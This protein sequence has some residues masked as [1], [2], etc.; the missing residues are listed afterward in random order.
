MLETYREVMQDHFDLPALR[1]VLTDI[2]KRTTRVVEADTDSPSPFASSLMFDFIASF[3]YEYDAPIAERRAAALALDRTLLADLLGEPE[4]RELLDSDAI[5]SVE[6]DLQHLSPDRRVR[7]RDGMSDMLRDIGPLT[8]NE[9]SDRTEQAEMAPLWLDE[10]VRSRRVVLLPVNGVNKYMAVE[11]IARLRDT[12]GVQPSPGIATD[13]L[14][15]VADPLGDVIGRYA[16]THGPFTDKEA[17]QVIGLPT[18]AIAEVLARLER[19][20]RVAAGAYRPGGIER[21]W[22]SIDVLRRLRRR[23]LASLA[24]QVEAVDHISY[25]RFLPA[26]QRFSLDR[27]T[28]LP[29]VVRQLSGAAI[30]ASVLERDVLAARIENPERELDSALATGDI[31]WVGR[32]PLGTR[33]GRVSLYLRDSYELLAPPVSTEMPDGPLH[34][35]LL[36]HLLERGASFFTDLYQAAGGGNP[37]D[38]AEALWDLVWAGAVTSDSIAA[39][40]AFTTKRRTK[41]SSRRQLPSPTPPHAAGRWYL[42]ESLRT[43]SPS[44][45]ERMLATINTMLDRYGILTRDV[46]L[47]EG[48]PGGFTGM[49]PA[50]SSLED[51]GQVRRGYF[52]E[53]LGGAQFGLPGAIDRLRVTDDPGLIVMAA[54]DPANPFGA[55]VPWP[56]T[57]GRPTRSAGARIATRDGSPIAWMDATGRSVCGFSQDIPRMASGVEALAK[58]HGRVSIGQVDGVPVHEHALAGELA[59]HGF[60]SGYKGYTLSSSSRTTRR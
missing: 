28:S 38:T 20:G 11:D 23:T 21:E 48:I 5:A 42:T 33:D 19:D 40:R 46:V 6:A 55:I 34:V 56:E 39:L 36:D 60:S 10:L 15:P 4:F 9:A 27:A 57:E 50:L 26:W 12:I 13:F 7:S 14:E 37:L 3:M 17:A 2:A 35:T 53:G 54:T 30:P 8:A 18:A 22:V 49:Y 47:A 58:A 32:E 25:A 44:P 59:E 24:R 41:S 1:E 29:D 43:S 16:R 51:V 31:V 45:E 52:I